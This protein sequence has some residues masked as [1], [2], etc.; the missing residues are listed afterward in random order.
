MID[1]ML[2]L[3]G[4][5]EGEAGK[6]CMHRRDHLHR[7]GRA[8]EEIR[9]AERHV[10]R[11]GANLLGNVGQHHVD[12]HHAEPA[13]IDGHHRAVTAQ[14]LAASAGLDEAER[15]P[16]AARQDQL[17]VAPKRRQAGA[18][19]RRELHPVATHDRLDL[20]I[21]FFSG[22]QSARQA[23]Q[24][25]FEFAAENG[26]DAKSAQQLLVHRRIEAVHA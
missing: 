5:I 2:D 19:G 10:F 1:E 25:R 24:P 11:T 18:I 16:F 8:V 4:G 17:R 15:L 21:A 22:A 23:D 12:R 6:R 7:M 3:D 9:V 14:V 13:L 20:F 26:L